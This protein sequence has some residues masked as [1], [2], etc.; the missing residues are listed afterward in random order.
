M[1]L[2][3]VQNEDELV[4][5]VPTYVNP[6]TPLGDTFINTGQEGIW[7][8]NQTIS[9]IKLVINSVDSNFGSYPEKVMQIGAGD[10]KLGLR[11]DGRRFND[12]Y[13]QVSFLMTDNSGASATVPGA[14]LT[15][16]SNV[17]VAV[18]RYR[19]WFKD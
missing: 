7:V 14:V 3:T 6:T 12:D 19:T 1:A 10:T 17:W 18:V 4:L 13:G 2:L 15:N 5:G 8:N 11:M 9:I 16:M